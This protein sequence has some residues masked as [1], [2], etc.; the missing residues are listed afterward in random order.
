[1]AKLMMVLMVGLMIRP[2]EGLI[3]GP[4]IDQW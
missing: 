2:L 1:M 4:M 3:V